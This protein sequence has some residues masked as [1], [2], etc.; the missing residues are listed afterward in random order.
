MIRIM[1]PLDGSAFAEQALPIALAIGRSSGAQLNLVTVRASMPFD[2]DGSAGDGYVKTVAAQ[3]QSHLVEPVTAVAITNEYTALHYPPPTVGVVAE[4][5]VR[6]A[7]DNAIDIIVMT[8]HGRGGLQ[9]SW[10]GSVTDAV[11]RTAPCPVLLVRP[12]GDARSAEG[13]IDRGIEHVLIP[14]DGSEAAERVLPV[15][16]TLGDAFGARYTLMRVVSPVVPSPLSRQAALLYLDDVAQELRASGVA[17]DT[18]VAEDTSAAAAIVAWA[19]SHDVDLIGLGTSGAGG[20]RRMVLGSV[21]DKVVRSGTVPTLICD[22]R[23]RP[24]WEVIDATSYASEA[25]GRPI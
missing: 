20:I 18:V 4:A 17:V 11:S 25:A 3:I 16:R 21:V 15:V 24:E 6:H 2:F 8:T 13:T 23:R 10:L 9:R 22:V 14:L 5:L 1:I 19:E 7:R 12:A